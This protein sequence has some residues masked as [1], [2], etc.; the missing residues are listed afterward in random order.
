M[1]HQPIT[2][3]VTF[4][5]LSN[6]LHFVFA[7]LLLPYLPGGTSAFF[8]LG[9]ATIE[10]A[11]LLT[12]RRQICFR[13]L[14][15]HI[16]FFIGIGFLVA[17]STSLNY[18]AVAFIDP[19]TAQLLVQSSTVFAL[20]LS[21]IWL[22]ERLNRYQWL[23]AVLSISG[24]FVISFQVGNY[25]RLG[26]FLVLTSAF[27]YALHAAVV[28]RY[29]EEIDFANFFF[30]RVASTAGFLLLFVVGRGEFIWPT[31]QAWVILFL[32]ATFDVVVSRAL[33]YVALRRL[34]M[35]SHA[36]VLTLTP[37]ITI[38]WSLALFGEIP[39]LQGLIGG[40]AVITGV[41]MVIFG[42]V[43]KHVDTLTIE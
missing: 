17:I 26:S 35:S 9:A 37:V 8:V 13:V 30:F 18:I 4:L 21:L 33:Y 6:S 22:R 11:V 15:R 20:G 14:L 1:S 39:T 40:T 41:L 42:V 28:K 34:Q 31:G 7:R 36:I 16:W 29:G 27:M 10:I 12:L 23:G 3:V 38:L 19:G 2:I 5:L 43:H 32:A 24:T 25:L